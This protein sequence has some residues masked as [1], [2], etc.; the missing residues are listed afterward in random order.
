MVE[1]ATSRLVTICLP[2]DP[3]VFMVEVATFQIAAGSEARPAANPE[4][5][6]VEAFR[7]VVLMFD[8]SEVDAVRMT[9]AVF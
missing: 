8:A 3:A 2:I 4:A 1:T 6:E 9:E 7:T 5:S